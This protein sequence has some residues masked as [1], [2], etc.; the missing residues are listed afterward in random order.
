MTNIYIGELY[1]KDK[2]SWTKLASTVAKTDT[3]QLYSFN[4]RV[5]VT[6]HVRNGGVIW[7]GQIILD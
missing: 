7:Q 3:S 1:G 6:N 2:L 5:N 4:P